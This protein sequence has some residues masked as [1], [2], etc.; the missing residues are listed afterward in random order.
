MATNMSWKDPD[1]AGSVI[2][3]P[4]ASRSAIKDLRIHGSG[5]ERNIYGSTRLEHSQDSSRKV[6]S[7]Q[8]SIYHQQQTK[9]VTGYPLFQLQNKMLR[10]IKENQ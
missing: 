8:R 9:K 2:N 1:P 5:S 7:L 3:W 4:L 10:K 6:T